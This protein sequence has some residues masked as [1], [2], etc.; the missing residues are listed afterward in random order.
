MLG[1]AYAISVDNADNPYVRDIGLAMEHF[2]ETTRPGAYLVDII[3]ICKWLLPY[4]SSNLDDLEVKYLP[5]WFPGASF[6]REAKRMR[7]DLMRACDRP[8][9]R[10]MKELVSRI[11]PLCDILRNQ[12]LQDA[13]NYKS[14]F[15]HQLLSESNLNHY[16]RELI[17]WSAMS[18]Y[19]G[20]SDTVSL[21]LFCI[22][23]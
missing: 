9:D 2:G 1:I 4:I 6:K 20:G 22:L 18:M 12:P 17:K 10:V 8:Y 3:P 14:S 19:L 7:A 15:F 11:C 5:E 23:I 21:Q 16:Q 13:G